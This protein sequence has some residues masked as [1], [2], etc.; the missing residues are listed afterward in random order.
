VLN[1]QDTYSTV[2]TP[3]QGDRETPAF[4]F[5]VLTCAARRQIA[6]KIIYPDGK[7]TPYSNVKYFF[8]K[9][10]EVDCLDDF[11]KLVLT[12]LANEP[13][14][15][16]IRGQLKPGLDSAIKHRRLL[17]PKDNDPA[18]IECPPRRWIPLDLDGVRVPGGLGS[19]D[20]V[21]EAG[22]HVRD[23]L[24]PSY[25]R[26]VRCIASATAST[27]RKGLCTARLRLFFALNEAVDNEILRYWITCLSEKYIAIDPSVMLAMQPIYTARPWFHGMADPVPVWSR[28]RLLD[29]Y[30]DVVVP[31][32]P[33]GF[34]AKKHKSQSTV[35][36]CS[37]MPDWMV[38]LA[39]VDAGFGIAPVSPA[40]EISNKAWSAIRQI[41]EM[42]DGCPKNGKGR[43]ESLNR[44]AYWLAKLYAEGEL[45]EGEARDAFF[46][47]AEGINNSDGKY[48]A[49][50]LQR[51]IDDAFSDI[52][53]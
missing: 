50:L 27:G 20:K 40:T 47:A 51:H 31:E 21:A 52:G 3:K 53:R 38:D 32:L 43:H 22:Y 7:E 17:Y 8:Y 1:R 2:C 49:A 9:Y 10:C 29:G 37:D 18:T 34:K 12:W 30:E 11:A 4:Q 6:T 28:V 44:A 45:P 5:S 25:F 26:G 46:T 42:L 24:L 13:K 33:R 14:R 23:N 41:I 39:E 35:H 48:D 19:P 15:F 36:V 16:I